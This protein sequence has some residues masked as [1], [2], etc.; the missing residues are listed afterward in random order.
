MIDVGI[1]GCDNLRGYELVRVL[2]NH[3]DVVLK[4][5]ASR[6]HAGE[7]LD[8]LVRGIV[9]ESDL[10][11]SPVGPLDEVDVVFVTHE[12]RLVEDSLRSIGVS[13]T[14]RVVDMSGSHNLDHGHGNRWV[15]GLSEMQR[16]VLVHDAE[17]V[18]VPGSAA[19]ASLLALMPMAR[20]LLL[21]SPVSLHVE[22]GECACVAQ[23]NE[24]G[25]TPDGLTREQW[26]NEQNQEVQLALVQC[27]PNFKQPVEMTISQQGERRTIEATARFK[28]GIDGDM[29]R[30]L[31]EQYYGDH[32]FVFLVDRP[33]V[34]ADV[35]N[36]N[37]CLIMLDKDGTA[38][39]LTVHAMMDV[40]LKGSA[41]M[42]V[43]VMNLM[44]GLHERVGLTLKG[45]GC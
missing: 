34:A 33:I 18:T 39:T 15:Y 40:L 22:L 25:T 44:Y 45:T 1:I 7:R 43:H 13:G 26:L 3:P 10:V 42:A 24:S 16:R 17:L 27:Q 41:G 14:T 38:G 28:C 2:I 31:Y 32:N 20:N 6:V 30:Q 8:H 5:V 29:V 4:W 19:A 23:D 37:K 11:V 21:N 9:G 35:E 36:T 12:R